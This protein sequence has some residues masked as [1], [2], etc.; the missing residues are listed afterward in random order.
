MHELGN[1]RCKKI[2]GRAV[3]STNHAPFRYYYMTRNS[4][5]LDAKHGTRSANKRTIKNTL[6][7]LMYESDKSSKIKAI[8]QGL[9]DGK[10]LIKEY[11]SFKG[12]R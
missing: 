2:F 8:L 1:L 6:K 5:Y 11:K 3:Y 12:V 4:Y 7:I 10:L 9:K